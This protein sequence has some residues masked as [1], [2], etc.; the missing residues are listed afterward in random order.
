[1]HKIDR[2]FAAVAEG[3]IRLASYYLGLE[4]PCSKTYVSEQDEPKFCHPLCNCEKC[5][6]I[7]ELSY[8]KETKPPIAIN[9]VNS[10]GETAL[11]IASAVGCT[12]IIQ[13]HF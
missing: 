5:V 9:A 6:S 2:L 13:V 1:M 12:E 4:G 7:E 3:D 8:E 10:S 11:H